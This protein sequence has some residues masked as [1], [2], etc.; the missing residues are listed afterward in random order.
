MGAL[1]AGTVAGCSPKS[2]SEERAEAKTTSGVTPEHRWQ[3]EAAAAW[4]TPMESIPEEQI[5]DGGSFDVVVVGGGQ[6]GTWCARSA[7]MNG[8]RVAVLEILP[9]DEFVY[10][11]GEVGTIN[12]QWA[13]DH[14]A[15]EIDE[16]EF[17]NELFRRNAGRSNQRLV[18]DYVANSGAYLDWA[19]E[20]LNDPDWT[21]DTA[22]LHVFSA[23]HSESMVMD[24]SGYKYFIGTINFR[25]AAEEGAATWNWGEKMMAHHRDQAI[26]DGAQWMWAHKALYLEK[27]DEGRVVA[28]VAQNVADESYV[29]LAVAKGVVLA[30][31]DFSANED[32]LRDINDEYRHLAETYGNIE[33]AAAGSMFG[34]RNGDGVKMGVWAGGHVEV[35]PRAGMNTGQVSVSAPWGSGFVILNQN[36]KRFCDECAGGAEGSGYLIPRQPRGSVVSIAD[37]AWREVAEKM[38]PC[39]GGID[40]TVGVAHGSMEAATATIASYEI[41]SNEGGVFC[42][43]TL[44]ELIDLI[45]IYD[46][47]QKKTALAELERFNE[48]AAAGKDEDFAMDPR[49]M[50]A[51]DTP[52]FYAVV[53][54]SD[55]IGVGLCQTAGLDISADHEVLD[56]TLNP[57]PGL[58][59]IGNNS[60]NRYI[61]NY[62]TPLSGMSLGFCLTEGMTLGKKLAEA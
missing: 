24:P 47:E 39:H 55:A 48:F 23:D 50:K 40:Q 60:G 27:D 2:A 49:I 9:E 30:A 1:A 18:R 38:P 7:S 34:I 25:P 4:R 56:E 41:G 44:E 61:V 20:D 17:M 33:A 14:G 8:A 37:A 53:Q 5:G 42:A 19:I 10:V 28:V 52:P 62:A 32:M 21:N 57:I 31:G 58:Y 54:A 46:D 16:E 3:S 29:R 26:A 43:N 22:N 36:G 51:L 15:V 6:S 11:G 12:C 45:G 59:S 13:L 35:G